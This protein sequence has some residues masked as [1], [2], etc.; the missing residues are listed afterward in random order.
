[1]PPKNCELFR[2]LTLLLSVL[3]DFFCKWSS[4]NDWLYRTVSTVRHRTDT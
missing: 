4:R 1:M 3:L 2:T